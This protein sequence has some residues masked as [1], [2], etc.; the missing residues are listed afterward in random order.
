LRAPADG[1]FLTDLDIGAMVSPG[2]SVGTVAGQAVSAQ[3]GGVLRGLIRPGFRVGR[4]VKIGD[5]DPRNDLSYVNTI[6]EK[7]RA[8]GGA[9]LG[10]VL[11]VYNR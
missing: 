5:V 10:A 8:L 6:S 11:R 7:A 2:Q 1:E 9:V 4:G 3:I